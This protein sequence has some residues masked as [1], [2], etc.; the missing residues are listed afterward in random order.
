MSEDIKVAGI[1]ISK[2]HFDKLSD[3]ERTFLTEAVYWIKGM[4]KRIDVCAEAIGSNDKTIA[5]I[6]ELTEL[7]GQQIDSLRSRIASFCADDVLPTLKAMG[8]K[9]EED[10]DNDGQGQG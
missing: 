4:E 9:K 2:E 1:T 7:E 3:G 5:M 8:F 10:V 6:E